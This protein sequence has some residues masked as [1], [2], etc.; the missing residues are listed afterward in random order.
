VT[1]SRI[2][3]LLINISIKLFD[4]SVGKD[5]RVL[6]DQDREL[7]LHY[8]S[9]HFYLCAEPFF[10]DNH[11]LC[12]SIFSTGGPVAGFSIMAPQKV[13]KSDVESL[14]QDSYVFSD[15]SPQSINSI[16]TWSY[17]SNILQYKS[18]NCLDDSSDNEKDDLSTKY[19]IIAQ[20]EIHKIT[21]RLDLLPYC[22]MIR[23]VLD[24][25]DIPTKMIFNK[26]KVMIGTF[27]PEHL[28]AMYKFSPT[29]NHNHN[30]KFLEGFKKEYEKYAKILSDLIKDWVSHPI[31][32]RADT[33][34]IYSISSLEPQFKYIAMMT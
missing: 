8:F 9:S 23:W 28:R 29:L 21:V 32:F 14:G 15:T 25:V 5:T 24:H 33:N 18:I 17:V 16:K 2:S 7:F 26:Q 22:D 11:C 13:P 34:E 19:K 27:M 10:Q 20:E 12:F 3:F 4:H 30:A 6:N 1:D 31:T